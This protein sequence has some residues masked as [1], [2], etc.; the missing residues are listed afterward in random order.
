MTRLLIAL[1][2]VGSL[3]LAAVTGAAASPLASASGTFTTTSATFTSA[4][5]AGGN[6]V[7]DLTSTI[8]YTGT[9]TGTSVVH[10]ILIFHANGSANFHDFETFTRTVNG[11]PGTVTFNDSG[12]GDLAAGAYQ[13]TA[14]IISGTGGLANLRGVMRQ[15]GTVPDPAKGPL[16]TYTAEL[17]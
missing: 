17:H 2:L 4:R 13:G 8:T 9:F 14:V 10:G 1:A 12:G 15:V 6:T 11:V 3:F 5:S 16:G 7:I